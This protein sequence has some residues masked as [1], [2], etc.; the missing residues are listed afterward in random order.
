MFALCA[1]AAPSSA[2]TDADRLA[3]IKDSVLE[4]D[5][6]IEEVTRASES[7]RELAD[8]LPAGNAGDKARK[9]VGEFNQQL[10]GLRDDRADLMSTITA[11]A[12]EIVNDDGSVDWARGLEMLAVPAMGIPVVGPYIAAAIGV[13]VGVWRL[14]NQIRDRR[15]VRRLL[16]DTRRGLRAIDDAKR[17]EPD[18]WQRLKSVVE[19]RMPRGAR[20][21][22][23]AIRG[24]GH[25]ADVERFTKTK[26]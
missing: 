14:F 18:A 2:Q 26:P 8:L 7:F 15:A 19:N 23:R 3:V 25:D 13:G 1:T 11:I 22:I 6:K 20:N 4:I 12:P 10:E 17:A 16:D 21:R 5:A 9:F 24:K